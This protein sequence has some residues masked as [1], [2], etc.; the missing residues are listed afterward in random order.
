MAYIFVGNLGQ[1]STCG[2]TP[3]P[4]PK[5]KLPGG[6]LSGPSPRQGE[7]SSSGQ[8]NTT[9]LKTDVLRPDNKAETNSTGNSKGG[10]KMNM[11]AYIYRESKTKTKTTSKQY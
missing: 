1:Y 9:A 4:P 6:P 7:F 11:L 10:A 5:K 3:Y 8:L 2:K